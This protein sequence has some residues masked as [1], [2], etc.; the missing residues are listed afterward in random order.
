[1]DMEFESQLIQVISPDE[2]G[3][4]DTLS[5]NELVTLLRKATN[6]RKT[7]KCQPSLISSVPSSPPSS[8]PSSLK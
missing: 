1:M 6:V 3:F 7:A 4:R 2:L 8:H 5:G